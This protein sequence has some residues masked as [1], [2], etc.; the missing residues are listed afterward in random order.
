MTPTPGR[1]DDVEPDVALLVN[2]G[3]ARVQPHPH[4]HVHLAGPGLGRVC[5]LSL[6]R[7]GH[8][9]AR[10]ERVPDDAPVRRQDVAVVVTEALEELSRVLD[11]GERERDRSAGKLG[12][13]PIVRSERRVLLR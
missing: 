6:D 2:R 11:V 3:L 5:A 4:T 1:A 9:V 13:G 7:G 10:G 12:H 8:G